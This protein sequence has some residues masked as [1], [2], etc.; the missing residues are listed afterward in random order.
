MKCPYNKKS[1]TQIQNWEQSPDEQ[2]NF[3]D[4]KV[5]TQ[6]VFELMNCEKENCGA[7]HNGRCCYAAISLNNE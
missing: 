6:T 1:E 5:I 2:Q 7:Y 3:T 4:G